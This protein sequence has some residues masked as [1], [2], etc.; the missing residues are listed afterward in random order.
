MGV[1][2]PPSLPIDKYVWAPP[3]I[4]GFALC[5]GVE[6]QRAKL[7]HYR[8]MAELADAVSWAVRSH[9]YR[10]ESY[11]PYQSKGMLND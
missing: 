3:H 7:K 5:A 9:F 4:T 6:K 1:R 10:F 11:C 2:V 8:G